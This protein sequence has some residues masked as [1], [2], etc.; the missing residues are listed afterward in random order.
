MNDQ[1]LALLRRAILRHKPARH[2]IMQTAAHYE[3][4][5]K[6][7]HETP[8]PPS[9]TLLEDHLRGR[10]TIAVPLCANGLTSAIV[11]DVDNEAFSRVPLLI[12]Q[13]QQRGL[14][15]WGELHED[16]NRG[17]VY[18]PFVELENAEQLKRLGDTLIAAAGLASVP[19][20]ELDNR[21]MN[22]AITRLPFGVHRQTL[23]RGL[24]IFPD[25]TSI[26]LNEQLDAGLALWCA[27]YQANIA[28][29]SALPLTVAESARAP[30]RPTKHG[31]A[32]YSAA[33]IQ[34]LYNERYDVCTILAQHGATRSSRNSWHCPCG[35][36]QHGDR[37]AS[38][39]IKK[40]R[41]PRYGAYI[42]QGFSGSCLFFSDPRRTY[43]AFN[44][45]AAL[46]RLS[47]SD[48][49]KHARHELGLK[50]DRQAQNPDSKDHDHHQRRRVPRSAQPL[51]PTVEVAQ[52]RLLA[53]QAFMIDHVLTRAARCVYTY[54]YNNT[55]GI[56]CRPSMAR[57]AAE[58][59][60]HERT[61]QRAMRLL[62]QRGHVITNHTENERGD[63]TSIYTISVP[64]AILPPDIKACKGGASRPPAP[65]SLSVATEPAPPAAAGPEQMHGAKPIFPQKVTLQPIC[66]DA[67]TPNRAENASDQAA[68]HAAPVP[69]PSVEIA[70][71]LHAQPAL[72]VSQ[73]DEEGPGAT[74]DPVGYAAWAETLD[75]TTE[76]P[77]TYS[78]SPRE[79]MQGHEY[80]LAELKRSQ[81]ECGPLVTSPP[82][83]PEV[84]A[85]R[86][87]QTTI[88]LMAPTILPAPVAG[89]QALRAE[90]ARL[91]RE[92]RRYFAQQAPTAGRQ[93]QQRAAAV[94]R[95]L[96]ELE[97][98]AAS[99][100]VAGT[101][102]PT[103]A[104]RGQIP[105]SEK[106]K[107]RRKQPQ[108][109]AIAT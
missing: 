100:S 73:I 85:P 56:T 101:T 42:V 107:K 84:A 5:G 75:P 105:C 30:Q 24:L 41:N 95:Q 26:D 87:H 89:V 61:A 96:A 94:R 23:R 54:L 55:D 102:E 18:I 79:V 28:D 2:G 63:Q 15:A 70:P 62:E 29:F 59:G 40:A 77:W 71:P 3:T 19:A 16:T 66:A 22:N 1:A 25:G 53:L 43:D 46:N 103:T 37:S 12:D 47:N 35:H 69:A 64:P 86:L 88:R 4:T 83:P 67:D 78:R 13:A 7:Y 92:A 81:A 20:A 76:R 80:G 27:R 57:I 44:V 49:L 9:T 98:S 31:E 48:M 68:P 6:K 93:T 45:Y 74:F 21:T 52:V 99:R 106:P 91:E 72:E 10:T 51:V 38:L 109:L 11:F 8:K 108:Q 17:Y 33:E 36:H 97:A 39:Q 82:P 58:T 34:R 32:V 50:S 60:I 14:W 65:P 104:E 90:L